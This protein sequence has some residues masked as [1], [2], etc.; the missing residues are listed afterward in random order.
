MHA[1]SSG[2]KQQQKS[3]RDQSAISHAKLGQVIVCF[4]FVFFLSTQDTFTKASAFLYSAT[5]QRAVFRDVTILVPARWSNNNAYA[6]ATTQ[7]FNN[8]DIIFARPIAPAPPPTEEAGRARRASE[9]VA[10]ASERVARANQREP[11][12]SDPVPT[13]SFDHQPAMTKMYAGCG[14]PGV[15][16]TMTTDILTDRRLAS[17]VGP[18]G[19][20]L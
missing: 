4:C 11:R 19:I 20:K 12:S 5:N 3:S 9:R 2:R 8:A 14:H 17:T 1:H 10:R 18:A 16:I 15:R 7:V 13:S 6:S